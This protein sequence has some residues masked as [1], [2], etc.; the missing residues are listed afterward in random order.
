[1]RHCPQFAAALIAMAAIQLV[2]CKEAS[3]YKK[4]EPAHVDHKE[5]EDIHKITLTEK[6]VERIDVKT[7]P[8]REGKIEG[9]P[10]NEA[11]RSVVPYSAL[12]YF[13]DGTAHV[14]TNPEKNVFIRQPVEVDYIEGDMVVLKSG[15]APG[16][17]VASMGAT[18]IYGTEVGVGH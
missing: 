15:P 12:I 13:A 14:Y 10:D 2:G 4:V 1:M 17:Q 6:A 11:S 8:V 18:E 3:T 9:A 7:A 5:G 16:T